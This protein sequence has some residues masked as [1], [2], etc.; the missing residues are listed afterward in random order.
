[1]AN[2]LLF[3]HA[4]GLTPGM[5]AFADVLREA[6]HTVTVPDLFE[7]RTF[8]GLD[9]GLAY[10][11]E[12]G[13]E[14]IEEA[15]VRIAGRFPPG[16]VYLGFSLGVLCAQRLAQTRPG[17][18]GAVLI[19]G[20]VPLGVFADSWPDGVPVQIHG[21]DEDPVFTKEGDLDAAVNLAESADDAEL[22]LYPGSSHLFA[23]I[24][25]DGYDEAAAP[26]LTARV[27]DFLSRIE[28]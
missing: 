5:D 24:S 28:G 7:G 11:Q 9:A 26:A 22:F 2:V 20:C 4:Q 16:M 27:L 8:A 18:R 12:L 6:G 15:G 1:M 25:L 13:L 17:A 19:S 23:D 3:H 21:M 14:E 10:A